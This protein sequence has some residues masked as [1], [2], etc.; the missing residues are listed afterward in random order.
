MKWILGLTFVFIFTGCSQKVI[1]PKVLVRTRTKIVV[2][3][4]LIKPKVPKYLLR[5]I[6]PLPLNVKE[7]FDKN[8][9]VNQEYVSSYIT[10]LYYD[11]SRANNDKRTLRKILKSSQ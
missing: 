9:T 5:E 7:L 1:E 6:T 10:T 4:K 2:K 3:Q 11:I 8:G